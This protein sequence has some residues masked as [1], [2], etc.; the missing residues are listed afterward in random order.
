MNFVYS[1]QGL[2]GKDRRLE[3]FFEA[4]PGATSWGVITGMIFLSFFFPMIAAVIIIAFD[5]Y[6][7]LRLF[8]MNLFLVLS[9]MVLSAE[10]DTDWI[11]M[12][13]AVSRS[14]GGDGKL[15]RSCGNDLVKRIILASRIK[16]IREAE[17]FD[18]KP[19]ALDDIYHLVII[20]IAK[21][22]REVVEP[23]VRSIAGSVFTPK[24]IL[25]I[26]TVEERAGKDIRAQM[27][28]IGDKYREHF[29]D[30]L[31]VSHPSGM[32]GEARVK[33]ANSTFAAKKAAAYFSGKGIQYENVIA[34]CFDADTVIKPQYFSCLAYYYIITSDRERASFQPI[35]VYHNNVWEAPAFARVLDV[36]ASFFQLIEATAP[37]ELVTF[38]SHSMS[39]K[40]L[41]EVG[42]WPVDMI[43]DDSAIFWKS[44]LHYHGDYRVIPIPV[45][46]S[47]DVIEGKN[48]WSTV[49][50]VYKQKRR[51][52]WGVENFPIVMRGFMSPNL[53]PFRKKLKHGF[54][55]FKG[56]VSWVI[57]PLFLNVISWFPA[58]FV[59][60]DFEQSVLYFNTPRITATIFILAVVGLLN[61]VWLSLLLLPKNKVKYNFSR[62]ALHALE[63]IL[64][65]PISVL[66]S[67]MP[68]LD[69]QTRLMFG[70][71]MEFWV[72]KKYR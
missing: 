70:K 24:R 41:V 28:A 14:D 39:F 34:S 4:V 64:I 20:P 17:G 3:R 40:A 61:C 68:A 42:Y 45:T 6:W 63:W 21:E 43:S 29:M 37:D 58:L 66:F 72:S 25:L 52:A 1:R 7:L 35:P 60:K 51:W 55:L 19:P 47:M 11:A 22:P 71:Y 10:K 48:F 30:L 38:S 5:L 69:A 23:G 32:E 59:G 15:I 36:G 13:K 49:A 67:A 53:I 46:L 12:S 65:P 57:W 33:G 2:K 18:Q 9:Y 44:F 50:N 62:R 31:V 26:M 27:D 8:Y 16:E 56:Q 54:K